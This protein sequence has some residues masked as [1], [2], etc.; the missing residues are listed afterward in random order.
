MLHKH[1]IQSTRYILS[2]FWQGLKRNTTLYMHA[3]IYY[4]WQMCL[5]RD[6]SSHSVIVVSCIKQ[7]PSC[8]KKKAFFPP[9]SHQWSM[10]SP[11]YTVL[12]SSSTDM[13][14]LM[15]KRSI[16]L[17]LQLHGK[18]FSF[19]SGLGGG[20]RW[21]VSYREQSVPIM[22]IL[23]GEGGLLIE[24]GRDTI[25]SE[26]LALLPTTPPQDSPYPHARKKY[27]SGEL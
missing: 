4:A 26:R 25:M 20:E 23:K 10:F 9:H 16:T 5:W 27:D 13:H 1:V 18:C 22:E 14:S 12:G 17:T 6:I 8:G 24:L 3:H 11:F 19:L 2:V 7:I 21:W 15:C